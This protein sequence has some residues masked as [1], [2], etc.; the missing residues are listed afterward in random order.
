[1]KRRTLNAQLAAFLAVGRCPS[2]RSQSTLIEQYVSSFLSFLAEAP[3][4]LRGCLA[5]VFPVHL[6]SRL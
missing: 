5:S 6:G 1:M 3:T 4:S 2:S